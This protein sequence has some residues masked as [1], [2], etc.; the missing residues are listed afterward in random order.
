MESMRFHCVLAVSSRF[1]SL[2][3]ERCSLFCCMSL[4]LRSA[5]GMALMLPARVMSDVSSMRL[6][7]SWSSLCDAQ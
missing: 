7:Q 1:S 4:G 5:S 6:A 3:C 2:I